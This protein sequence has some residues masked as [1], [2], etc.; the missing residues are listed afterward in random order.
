MVTK[1]KKTK[2]TVVKPTAKRG[3][4][5]TARAV[6]RPAKKVVARSTKKVV[7]KSVKKVVA[8]SARKRVKKP[9]TR[10]GLP[11]TAKPAETTMPEIR[12]E[13]RPVQELAK[14]PVVRAVIIKP[15]T[16][17]KLRQAQ[18]ALATAEARRTLR[19]A[20]MP[21]FAYM[22]PPGAEH[23]FEVGNTVEVF[24][25]HEKNSDRIR[26]W[27]KG[28]VVQVDNKLV[29]VQF[30]SNVYLTDGWMVPDHILWYPVS[31]DQIRVETF[32]KKGIKRDIP[33]Y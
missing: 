20:R 24:C 30:R 1:T 5:S 22:K 9:V 2:K 29:A 4:K 13:Y 7:T 27:V 16:K 10:F 6:K 23:I 3:A 18:S 14:N 21:Q 28:I 19:L 32:A 25:D 17:A 26:G 15:K 33:E 11:L 31:S 8:K 12:P